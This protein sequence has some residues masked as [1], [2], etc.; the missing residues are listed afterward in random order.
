MLPD[1]GHYLNVVPVT[2]APFTR[3]GRDGTQERGKMFNRALLVRGGVL[4]HCAGVD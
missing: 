3:E 1:N 2:A 4:C